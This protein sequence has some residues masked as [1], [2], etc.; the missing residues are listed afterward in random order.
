MSA[1]CV[2]ADRHDAARKVNPISR[3]EIRERSKSHN[4]QDRIS[5]GFGL[6]QYMED[7]LVA[8]D[9]GSL[10][11][12]RGLEAV[13]NIAASMTPQECASLQKI[14]DHPDCP[15]QSKV[16]IRQRVSC[17]VQTHMG[18]GERLKYANKLA[19]ELRYDKDLGWVGASIM[20][21]RLLAFREKRARQRTTAIAALVGATAVCA[22]IAFVVV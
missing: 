9:D 14:E 13:E 11:N 16:F 10:L 8:E 22:A 18:P 3:E 1:I 19:N 12:L 20:E 15:P 5:A 21:D 7:V 6:L 2:K 4:E 17:W